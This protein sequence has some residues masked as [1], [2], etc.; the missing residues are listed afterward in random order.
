M[1]NEYRSTDDGRE[2]IHD[3][4]I[5]LFSS[6]VHL[7]SSLVMLLCSCA[8]MLFVAGCQN[9]SRKA[10][11]AEEINTLKQEKIELTGQIEQLKTE[12]KQLREQIK[13]L[14]GLAPEERGVK[15]HDLQRIKIGKYTNFY[16][17]DNDGKREILIVYVRPVD[18]Q[19]DTIKAAGA[20][21][22]KLVD[23]NKE[24]GPAVLGQWH[25]KPSEL[26]KF[27]LTS[28]MSSNYRL[29]FDLADKIEALESTSAGLTLSVTFT[30]SLTGKAFTEQKLIKP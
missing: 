14:S 15:A 4:R 2:M 8:L 18:S 6:L 23:L 10:P 20:V 22:V 11:L 25:I 19:G 5:A 21:D 26:K 27:W 28:F 1:S 3:G 29:T 13:A 16:D 30:D 24:Q 7:P 12:N 17:K 9:A